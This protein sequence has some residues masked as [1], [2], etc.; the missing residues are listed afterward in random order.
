MSDITEKQIAIIDDSVDDAEMVAQYIEESI[1]DSQ[2]DIFHDC[3]SVL[4]SGQKYHLLIIDVFLKNENGIRMTRRLQNICDHIVL[5][6][7]YPTKITSAICYKVI[8]IIV[9]TDSGKKIMEYL[10]LIDKDYLSYSAILET[11]EGRVR[12]MIQSV[13]VFGREGRSIY[14]I[15]QSKHEYRLKNSSLKSLSDQFGS[16]F[17]RANKS[18]YV[19]VSCIEKIFGDT[20]ILTNGVT[21]QMSRRMIGKMYDAFTRSIL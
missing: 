20:I 10:K 12:V 9:K 13:T 14:L 3:Q 11:T 6:T 8:G 19:N 2:I 1:P 5:S 7:S 17:Q 15:M 18:E 4:K 16:G 21:I